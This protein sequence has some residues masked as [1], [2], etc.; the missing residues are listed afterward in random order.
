MI[1]K[2]HTDR[3]CTA[4]TV[5]C[6]FAK[7]TQID[8]RKN[9][10]YVVWVIG[11]KYTSKRWQCREN[12][13]YPTWSN[14]WGHGGTACT[15]LSQLIRWIRN[16]PV[17]D[18]RSWRYWSSEKMRLVDP[19]AIPILEN[20]GY[21]KVAKCVLCDQPIEGGIDW[22]HL[23]KVSGPCCDPWSGCKQKARV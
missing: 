23:K 19:V 5:L 22:W 2:I 21:P 1:S 7:N 11:G 13:F 9:G 14:K 3:L 6:H 17:L 18:I 20:A 12:D 15:A 4:N 8:H 16:L 10:L